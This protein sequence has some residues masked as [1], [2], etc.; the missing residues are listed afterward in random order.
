M[1]VAA[2]APEVRFEVT[3]RDDAMKIRSA[4]SGGVRFGK[5]IYIGSS[6]SGRV[7]D[8]LQQH[9]A[10]VMFYAGGEVSELGRSS[11][12]MGKVLGCGP[13][14]VANEGGGD[15]AHV[16]RDYRIGALVAGPVARDMEA[17][18]N[19]AQDLLCDPEL[20]TRCHR[21]AEVLFPLENG[22]AAYASLHGAILGERSRG[23]ERIDTSG[24]Q[25]AA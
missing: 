8:V 13:P 4:I 18:W 19:E 22:P 1:A 7:Q 21:A 15:V 25:E 12:R 11:T 6:S 2:R 10:S 24:Q 3:T 9:M 14:V 20:P 23:V 5:H 16:I 17:A